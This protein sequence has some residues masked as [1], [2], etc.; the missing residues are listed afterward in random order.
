[1]G[2]WSVWTG[3][4]NPAPLPSFDGRTVQPFAPVIK[5]AHNMQNEH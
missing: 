4:E 3:A 2:Q 1:V 5:L